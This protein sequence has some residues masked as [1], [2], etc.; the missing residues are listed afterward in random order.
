[1]CLHP[2][3]LHLAVSLCVCPSLCPDFSFFLKTRGEGPGLFQC[4]L[5]LI[6]YTCRG[7]ISH[8]GHT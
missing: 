1:M 8:S 6:N 5:I 2:A 4:D 7:A 3:S